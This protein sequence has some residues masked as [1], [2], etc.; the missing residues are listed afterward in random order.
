MIKKIVVVGMVLMLT[1]C[2][3]GGSGSSSGTS[4]TTVSGT[5][6]EGALITGA[7][8]LLK[9]ANGKSAADATTSA[10]G[11]YSIDV[12]GLSA[13]FLV[14]VTG[15]N[16]TY[17]TLAQTAGTANINPIT[18]TVVALAAANSD[19]LAVF[20]KLTPAQIATINNN[21]AAK[22]ALVTTALQTALPAGVTA[23]SYFTGYSGPHISDNSLRW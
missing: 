6:S 10:T 4:V 17:V 19:A 2:G 20:T 12:T 16:G 3:G 14:A 21:Y 15:N 23:A 7:R 13:P 1:A 18:T 22:T 5:A 9:D 11:S 8:V